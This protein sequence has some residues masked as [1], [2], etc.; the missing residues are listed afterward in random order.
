MT[1]LDLSDL[2]T[3]NDLA[4]AFG[5]FASETQDALRAA[6]ADIGRTQ[7]WLGERVNH[8]QHMVERARQD[9]VRAEAD[10]RRCQASGYRDQQ[11]Y[12]HQPDCSH[13]AYLLERA[14]AHLRECENRLRTAQVWRSRLEQAASDYQRTEARLTDLAG[15]HTERTRAFLERIAAKYAD[16]QAAAGLVGGALAAAAV[17]GLAGAAVRTLEAA[18]GRAYRA[19]G[20][21][22]E[23]LAQGVTLDALGLHEVG[24]DQAQHGFDRLV[25][26]PT[27][28][29]IVLESKC[30]DAGQL[31]LG[32]GYG[33]RQC[34][35]G[36][37]ESVARAMTDPSNPALCTPANAA[38]G[39]RIL[40]QGAAD[41]PVLATV[42]NA[43][44]GQADIYLRLDT[45][46]EKWTLLDVAAPVG[47][48]P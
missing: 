26:G 13:Q 3:L 32:E 12:Y 34:S 11:G 25:T 18:V 35:A 1:Q 24:F 31:K 17:L 29:V 28:Q 33:H 20:G 38:I 27:G 39:Q 23:E 48:E 16:V 14:T 36:W 40:E 19:R 30:S 41:T 43:S 7:E 10:L 8:W 4:A 22:G 37:V 46:A 44:T 6:R 45:A 47:G 42:I 15:G 2:Q 9:V 5:R 21:L